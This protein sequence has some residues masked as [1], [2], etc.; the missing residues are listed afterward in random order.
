MI[1]GRNRNV[2]PD[3]VELPEH[4]RE[5]QTEPE[6]DARPTGPLDISEAESLDGLLDL[7]P[8]KL[9]ITEGLQVRLDVDKESQK[10]MGVTLTD[11]KSTLQI[12][13]YAAPK[14]GGQWLE[15]KDEIAEAMTKNNAVVE[16]EQ[17]RIGPEL[18][19]RIPA[20]LPDGR[21]AQRVAR[22]VGVDGPR[23]MVRGVLGGEAVLHAE[24]AEKLM[25]I[26]QNSVIDRGKNPLPPRELLTLTAPTNATR[27]DEPA[28]AQPQPTNEQGMPERGP[29]ITETR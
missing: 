3:V 7:G 20:K 2:Q 26:L 10:I 16:T 22:F 12:Q 13:I 4:L 19:V 24:H 11:N 17:G 14:S 28:Q 15:V 29:E 6:A 1:F 18:L 25:T 5:D 27:A 9:A 21:P 8:L 23:W